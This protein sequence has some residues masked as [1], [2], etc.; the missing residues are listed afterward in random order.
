MQLLRLRSIYY[1][2]VRGWSIYQVNES[3]FCDTKWITHSSRWLQKS[4]DTFNFIF[5][6][7]VAYLLLTIYRGFFPR[8][9][10]QSHINI[11]QQLIINVLTRLF[12]FLY[13]YAWGYIFI[14]DSVP[15]VYIINYARRYGRKC[16][17]NIMM[18]TYVLYN[19]GRSAD[20][21]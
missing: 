9:T 8:S 12:F 17:Y 10:R 6:L 4:I 20:G 3:N 16:K 19:N 2:L 11:V 15:K 5:R 13:T 18:Y 14:F 7:N 21:H 1:T